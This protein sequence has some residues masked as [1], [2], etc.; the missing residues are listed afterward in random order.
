MTINGKRLLLFDKV[1][2][3]RSNNKLW[4]RTRAWRTDDEQPMASALAADMTARV[5]A[6]RRRDHRS[7]R[8]FG[9]QAGVARA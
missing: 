8:Q 9:R 2:L 4:A 6:H 7:L 3:C 5:R 1:P